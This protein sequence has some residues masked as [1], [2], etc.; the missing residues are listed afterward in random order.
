MSDLTCADWL[1]VCDHMPGS[2]RELR[3][4][5]TCEAPV[6]G[7]SVT[8][9]AMEPQGSNPDDLLLELVVIRG[10]AGTDAITQYPVEYLEREPREYTTVTVT[11]VGTTID[12]D[13][14]E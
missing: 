8:Q 3:V 2:P 1:A 7:L 14:V 13:H 10:P 11:S 5:G 6:G 12:V 4:S 9:K